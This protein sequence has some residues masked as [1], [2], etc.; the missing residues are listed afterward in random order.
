M[1]KTPEK[2]LAIL[3][4][5]RNR[6]LILQR[7]L[8]ELLARGFSN[9]PLYVYDDASTDPDVVR[10]VVKSWPGAR[11]LRGDVRTGQAKGRNILMN[12]CDQE[13]GLFLDD[14]SWPENTASIYNAFS[15]FSAST[16]AIATFQYRSLADGKLSFPSSLGRQQ[17]NTFLGGANISY[18]PNLK[19]V[20][21]FRELFVYG[22]EE[23]ELALRL[24]LSG[25]RIEYFPEV[26]I[27]HNHF[28]SKEENRDYSEYDYLYAR[29]SV[30]M[31]SLNL[32]LPFGL[33]YGIGRS[34]LRLFLLKRN[35][36]PNCRGLVAGIYHTFSKKEVRRP[37]NWQ[38]TREWL[39]F[40]RSFS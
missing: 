7:T 24:W 17:I 40:N 18:L 31:S 28:E 21:G 8:N 3:L 33:L 37:A 13:Y 19:A 35:Y 25:Y 30:L 6:P 39:K 29:N 34:L 5:T 23:P 15:E 38:Q 26:V 4:P 12:T 1:W 9:H 20:G 27:H 11:H 14:D 32:A 16:C 10:Q 22:Y 36:F 2:H